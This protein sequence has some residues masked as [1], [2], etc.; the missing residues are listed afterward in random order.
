M[1]NPLTGAI[2]LPAPPAR[3][4]TTAKGDVIANLWEWNWDSVASECTQESLKQS[5]SYWWDVYQPYSYSLNSRF[6]S[7]AKFSAMI[8]ACN[9]IHARAR[10][11][12]GSVTNS[13]RRRP[14][15]PSPG[16]PRRRLREAQPAIRGGNGNRGR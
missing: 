5:S 2:A 7:Q 14:S 13:T 1:S 15:A 10:R 16:Q 11:T 3:A 9:K 8:T 6:G 4:D 12:G